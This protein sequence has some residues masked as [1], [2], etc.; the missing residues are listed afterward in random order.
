[1]RGIRL[2]HI[3]IKVLPE[4]LA[5]ATRAYRR[6]YQIAADTLLIDLE[7]TT[8]T[9]NTRVRW[10]VRVAGNTV[11]VTTDN[12]I[13]RYVDA[14]TRPHI[15]RVRRA[16]WLRFQAGYQAKT[17]PGSLV[18]GA[19][20]PSGPFRFAKEVKHPGTKARNFSRALRAKWKTKWPQMVRDAIDQAL[21]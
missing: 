5:A 17:R 21:R 13:W 16:R 6:V 19:G 11:T 18:S 20:G 7:K 12:A 14:G 4:K 9:W 15:I 3:P 10:T 8:A 2:E 1:M